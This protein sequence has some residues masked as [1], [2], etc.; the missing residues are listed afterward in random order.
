MLPVDRKK[1]GAASQ[2]PP[3]TA[4]STAM[5]LGP[6]ELFH[7]ES[8]LDGHWFRPQCSVAGAIAAVMGVSCKTGA[9]WRM[10]FGTSAEAGFG[11]PDTSRTYDATNPSSCG[12]APCRE[13]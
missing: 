6:F 8:E 13:L 12:V 11:W 1:Q 7:V 9:N 5:D 4:L 2:C 10:R 3:Y